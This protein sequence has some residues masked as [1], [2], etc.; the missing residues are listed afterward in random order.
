MSSADVWHTAPE[1]Y[2]LMT[3]SD[4]ANVVATM[5]VVDVLHLVVVE[6]L[7]W[8]SAR[9]AKGEASVSATVIRSKSVAMMLSLA[10]L[11]VEITWKLLGKKISRNIE[12]GGKGEGQEGDTEDVAYRQ[13]LPYKDSGSCSYK[14]ERKKSERKNH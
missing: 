4:L 7:L 10:L 5:A 8:A 13:S 14:K 6:V 1:L 9:S 12:W 3:K 11:I 2:R